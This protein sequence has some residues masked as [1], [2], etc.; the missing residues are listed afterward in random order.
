MF[1]LRQIF[2]IISDVLIWSLRNFQILFFFFWCN[3]LFD[4]WFCSAFSRTTTIFQKIWTAMTRFSSIHLYLQINLIFN[5]STGNKS[6]VTSTICF[7]VCA[8]V[9]RFCIIALH[10]SHVVY[11]RHTAAQI[12]SNGRRA[13]WVFYNWH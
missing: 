5:K 11:A 9:L 6:K 1:C 2:I 7:V 10:T 4:C 3:R 13:N 8:S 12:N